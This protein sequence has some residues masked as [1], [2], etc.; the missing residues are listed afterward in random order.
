MRSSHW[1][2]SVRKG[3]LGNFTKFTGKQLYQSVIFKKLKTKAWN[4]IKKETLSQVFSCNF[5]KFFKNTFL[6]EHLRA[7][8]SEWF[9]ELWNLSLLIIYLFNE[10]TI[11]IIVSILSHIG[12][13]NEIEVIYFFANN[14]MLSVIDKLI[15]LMGCL[16]FRLF[17]RNLIYTK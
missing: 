11:S 12:Y 16:N 15:T 3:I 2:C 13:E 17:L 5:L 1:R 4:F 10:N 6:A 8:A 7:T 14:V 9:I